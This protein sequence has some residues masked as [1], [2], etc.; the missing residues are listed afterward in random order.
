MTILTQKN[1][2]KFVNGLVEGDICFAMALRT[3]Y[4]HDFLFFL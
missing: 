1:F 2:A 3:D 4:F